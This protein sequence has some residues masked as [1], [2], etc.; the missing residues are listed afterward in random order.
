MDT[1]SLLSQ[2]IWG[3]D[4]K[5]LVEFLAEKGGVKNPGDDNHLAQQKYFKDL[6]PGGRH[7]LW[8]E[9]KKKLS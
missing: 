3:P 6:L 4:K 8:Q 5:E 7:H 9:K 2:L 1:P